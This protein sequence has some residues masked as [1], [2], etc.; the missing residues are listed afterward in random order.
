MKTTFEYIIIGAGPAGVQLAYFLSQKGRDYAVL[1][2]NARAGSFFET[3]PRHRMLIS[4]NKIYTG[5]TDPEF[6]MRHDWNSLLTD[7]PGIR[8][9]AYDQEYFPSAD[10]LV[11]Y[12]N[13]FATEHQLNIHYDTAIH[14]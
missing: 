1:E 8:F 11:R 6:N 2:R 4:I 7:G 5:S 14:C 12:L 9:G 13:D 10:N 3:F